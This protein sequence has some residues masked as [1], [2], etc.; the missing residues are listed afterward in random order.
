M[1][2]AHLGVAAFLV[3]VTTV[4]THETSRDVRL[5]PGET[6]ELS[7]YAFRFVDVAAVQGPNYRALQARIEVTRNGHPVATLMPEKRMYR[8]QATP[9][10]E[11]AIATDLA[12]DLYV[13]LG[14]PQDDGSWTLRLQHKP[15]VIWLWLGAVIMAAGGILAAS[16]RR[17]RRRAG[18]AQPSP[19]MRTAG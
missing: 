3:G 18:A 17:Y 12:R 7:G 9:L 15:M 16:D 19:T 11:A 4:S 13:S 6:A 5:R 1:W 14:D 2:F 10:T 8:V